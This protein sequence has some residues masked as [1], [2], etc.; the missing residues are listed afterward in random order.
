MMAPAAS[1]QFVL[2]SSHT[3]HTK[4]LAMNIVIGHRI[5]NYAHESGQPPT[6]MYVRVA[7]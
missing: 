3:Q 6:Y 1:G 2:T 4:P 7:S 5:K